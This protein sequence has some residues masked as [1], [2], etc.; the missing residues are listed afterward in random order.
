MIYLLAIS[1]VVAIYAAARV[2]AAFHE[3]AE[4]HRAIDELR[5]MK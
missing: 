3:I 1:F 4:L 2:E 5:G